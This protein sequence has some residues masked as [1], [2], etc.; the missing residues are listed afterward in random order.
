MTG[1][2]DFMPDPD[3]PFS[4]DPD[5]ESMDWIKYIYPCGS[6]AAL[7]A[8]ADDSIRMFLACVPVTADDE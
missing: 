8:D 1:T 4:V 6:R 2:F 7:A 3:S 5:G